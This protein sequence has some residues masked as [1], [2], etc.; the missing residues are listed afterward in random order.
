MVRLCGGRSFFDFAALRARGYAPP[1]R[2]MILWLLL[3]CGHGV[4][5]SGEIWD[6]CAARDFASPARGKNH[7]CPAGKAF[8]RPAKF[9]MPVRRAA[10][11]GRLWGSAPFAAPLHPP[12]TTPQEALSTSLAWRGHASYA[13]GASLPRSAHSGDLPPRRVNARVRFRFE[14]CPLQPNPMILLVP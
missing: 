10:R 14:R 12:R 7:C 2:G 5:P 8:R 13:A 6:A 1:R 4:S 3:P 9:G 11:R